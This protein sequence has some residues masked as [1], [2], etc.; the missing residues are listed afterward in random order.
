MLIKGL[1]SYPLTG[2]DQVIVKQQQIQQIQQIDSQLDLHK[3]MQ[4]NANLFHKFK[5]SKIICNSNLMR[6]KK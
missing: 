6:L 3:V 2:I 4:V 5:I 1:M